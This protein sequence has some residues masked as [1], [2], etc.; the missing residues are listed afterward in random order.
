VTIPH[1]EVLCRRGGEAFEHHVTESVM[2]LEVLVMLRHVLN[3]SQPYSDPNI[4]PNTVPSMRQ[5][6]TMKR[7]SL[8]ACDRIKR[9]CVIGKSMRFSRQA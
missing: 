7:R 6:E 3:D 2:K 4:K 9:N 5:S 1:F 8:V